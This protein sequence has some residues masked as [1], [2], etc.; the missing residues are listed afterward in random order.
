MSGFILK[1]TINRSPEI[2]FDFIT[3]AKNMV[4]TLPT[5]QKLEK[6]TDGEVGVGTRYRQTR[7]IAGQSG[8]AEVK[9]TGFD[10]PTLFK[11]DTS[12]SGVFAS[13]T[14]VINAGKNPETTDISCTLAIQAD[15]F[16]KLMLPMIVGIIEREDGDMLKRF[17]KA[18][19]A[20]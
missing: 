20:L 16:K 17:K 14:Y 13:Y 19:E 18:I 15:G 8:E 9:V 5:M 2:V 12:L 6:M 10:R 11:V 3:D 7:L 4:A 1:E